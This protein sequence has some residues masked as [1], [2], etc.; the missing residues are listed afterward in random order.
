MQHAPF[1]PPVMPFPMPPPFAIPPIVPPPGPPIDQKVS[2]ISYQLASM[3]VKERLSEK[4]A[5][6]VHD[7]KIRLLDYGDP[8]IVSLFE[9]L[10]KE[11]IGKYEVVKPQDVTFFLVNNKL[12]PNEI[13]IMSSVTAPQPMEVINNFYKFVSDGGRLI[14]INS[15]V[16]AFGQ[17][18]QGRFSWLPPSTLYTAKAKILADQEILSGFSTDVESMYLEG[19]RFPVH[20]LENSGV[21]VLLRLLTPTEE[22]LLMKFTE[23]K[24]IVYVITT[25][26]FTSEK[27]VEDPE[28]F[29]KGLGG[30]AASIAAWK[31]ALNVG[32][33]D[34]FNLGVSSIPFVEVI[35]KILTREG[36]VS[37]IFEKEMEE[38][39]AAN[40]P[41]QIPEEQ[42][43]LMQ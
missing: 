21:E 23:G 39:A 14:V 2:R 5:K 9:A 36:I 30:S 18:F 22:P 25:R 12:T 3:L 1:H 38:I 40:P 43:D 37:A 6:I 32:Y 20:V 7:T 29:L 17:I 41:P 11:N 35:A 33:K 10:Q 31:C 19:F 16:S 34:A 8:D 27:K 28:K 42:S 4:E 15:S 26:L 24:G 13:I